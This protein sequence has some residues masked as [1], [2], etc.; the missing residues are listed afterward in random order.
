MN[1]PNSNSSITSSLNQLKI[2]SLPQLKLSHTVKTS[3]L[4]AQIVEFIVNE[5]KLIPHYETLSQD[6][7]LMNHIA[8]LI[9]NL[10]RRDLDPKLDKKTLFLDIIKQLFPNLNTEQLS[11]LDNFADFIV[12]HNLVSKVSTLSKF[13]SSVKKNLS[14]N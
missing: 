7:H 6:L 8:N 5:V 9:E 12:S 4:S 14:S 13:V 3:I 2:S 11:F 10:E 1:N